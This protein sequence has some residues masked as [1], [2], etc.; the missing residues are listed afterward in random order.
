MSL[1]N[2]LGTDQ[3]IH[4]SRAKAIKNPAMRRAGP[5]RVRIHPIHPQFGPE[6]KHALFQALRT[7][8]NQL[9]P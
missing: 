7:M 8:T 9:K 4:L 2:H 5:G 1:G 3:D 6:R